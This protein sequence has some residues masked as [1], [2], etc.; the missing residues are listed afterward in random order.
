MR[1]GI[2]CKRKGTPKRIVWGRLIWLML[3]FG[4]KEASFSGPRVQYALEIDFESWLRSKYPKELPKI[5]QQTLGSFKDEKAMACCLDQDIFL[6][7]AMRMRATLPTDVTASSDGERIYRSL[8]RDW[9]ILQGQM[10]E[11]LERRLGVEPRFAAV[12]AQ[13]QPWNPILVTLSTKACADLADTLLLTSQ[14]EMTFS[15]P[16]SLIYFV[17]D[18]HAIKPYAQDTSFV[19]DTF[20][21]DRTLH[22]PM[23]YNA[24][25]GKMQYEFNTSSIAY[26]AIEDTAKVGR[27]LRKIWKERSLF[28]VL[29]QWNP[30]PMDSLARQYELLAIPTSPDKFG[31][32]MKHVAAADVTYTQVGKSQLRLCFQAED[33]QGWQA[34]SRQ[35][36]NSDIAALLD[37]RLL[38][39]MRWPRPEMENQNGPTM[40]GNFTKAEIEALSMIIAAPPLPAP[41]RIIA[42]QAVTEPH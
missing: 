41:I 5:F 26:V 9:G 14:G 19:R 39:F 22:P 17:H 35:S 32:K 23:V 37:D 31:W 24:I 6:Q 34:F 3:I 40:E 29:F 33:T 30:M 21:S 27:F 13:Q 42:R 28:P 36:Q 16:V 10:R 4:C 20:D 7:I 8:M 15:N 2:T 11:A 25:E 1:S 12:V 18:L 38:A